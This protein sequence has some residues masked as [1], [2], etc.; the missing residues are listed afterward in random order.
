MGRSTPSPACR[1]ASTWQRCV[2]QDP[3]PRSRDGH[4]A[5]LSGPPRS[6][7]CSW[8]CRDCGV[9]VKAA[10]GAV[11]RRAIAAMEAAGGSRGGDRE[12]DK[13]QGQGVSGQMKAAGDGTLDSVAEMSNGVDPAAVRCAARL[14]I[15]RPQLLMYGPK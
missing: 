10:A 9:Q 1:A 3:L 14:R 7:A 15:R 2:H 4:V 12:D 6:R 13:R 8:P 5:A 11:Q